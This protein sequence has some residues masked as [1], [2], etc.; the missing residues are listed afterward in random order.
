M[1]DLKSPRESPNK[2]FGYHCVRPWMK[3][4]RL[5]ILDPPRRSPGS[6]TGP[7]ECRLDPSSGGH[8]GF[9]IEGSGR[10]RRRLHTDSRRAT[11]NLEGDEYENELHSA[12][13]GVAGSGDPSIRADEPGARH[14][15][16][17]NAGSIYP[18]TS[19]EAYE[20]EDKDPQEDGQ[21]QARKGEGCGTC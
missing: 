7:S 12:G 4:S 18:G 10:A 17:R 19:G 2:S 9:R 11:N 20:G 21:G 3:L 5:A 14:S 15:G 6:P 13:D 16:A 8:L 1:T